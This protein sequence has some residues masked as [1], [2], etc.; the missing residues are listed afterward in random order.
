MMPAAASDARKLLLA[1]SLLTTLVQGNP[2]TLKDASPYDCHP[3]ADYRR[4]GDSS[5]E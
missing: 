1:K 2:A 3:T 4:I 5:L